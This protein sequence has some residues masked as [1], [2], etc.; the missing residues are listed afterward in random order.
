MDVI[1]SAVAASDTLVRTLRRTIVNTI[2]SAK[3]IG[4]F[5]LQKA[6]QSMKNAFESKPV[7]YGV[8]LQPASLCCSMCA[9]EG[10]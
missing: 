2:T 3:A 1:E 8:G 10:P 7:T 5:S 9:D 4:C 6:A